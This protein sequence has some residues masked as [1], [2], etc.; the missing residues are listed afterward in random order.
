M[1]MRLLHC[2]NFEYKTF[3]LNS[4]Y[5][6]IFDRLYYSNK[7][8]SSCYNR[9]LMH[10]FVIRLKKTLNCSIYKTKYFLF[11][12]IANF[13]D[14]I[15]SIAIKISSDKSLRNPR[16]NAPREQPREQGSSTVSNITQNKY[17]R[18]FRAR[19]HSFLD[20]TEKF[21]LIRN[22]LCWKSRFCLDLNKYKGRRM[23][24]F[25]LFWIYWK[26]FYLG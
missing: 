10:D 16:I 8:I 20:C 24:P 23:F 18:I 14:H 22:G 21:L 13:I 7:Y 12:N 19:K 6:N 3:Q 1:I 4:N 9:N 15:N 11:K 5:A 17:G 26:Y 2:F 25:L